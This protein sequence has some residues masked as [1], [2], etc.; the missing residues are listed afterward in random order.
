MNEDDIRK[1]KIKKQLQQKY[2]AKYR[3]KNKEKVKEK[4]RNRKNKKYAE[5]PVYRSE[6]K[7]RS[8]LSRKLKK[9]QKKIDDN[10]R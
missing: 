8:R 3:D 1:T 9:L 7:E 4:D 5:D 6:I 2:A 10:V